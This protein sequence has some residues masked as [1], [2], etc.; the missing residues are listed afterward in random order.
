MLFRSGI[1]TVKQTLISEKEK[2]ENFY[3][4]IP[5]A[6]SNI[7]R[8]EDS[9]ANLYIVPKE[10]VIDEDLLIYFAAALVALLFLEWLLQSREQF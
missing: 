6:Q 7:K 5:A 9:L 4:K 10:Q 3:V 8:N 2:V 1:Y